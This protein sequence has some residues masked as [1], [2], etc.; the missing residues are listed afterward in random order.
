[1]LKHKYIKVKS[2]ISGLLWGA[3]PVLAILLSSCFTGIEG[4]KKITLSRQDRKQTA[5]TAE[6]LYLSDVAPSSSLEWESGK[7]FFVADSRA[8]VLIDAVEVASPGR[9]GL[10]RGDILRYV[11]SRE[12]RMPDGSTRTVI[13]FS[14]GAGEEFRYVAADSATGAGAEG[15]MSDAIP[16]LIDPVM[17]KAVGDRLRGTD[18]WTRS[19]LWLDDSDNR[20]SGLKYD[21][22]RVTDVAPG[23]MV[24]PVRVT[25]EDYSGNRGSYL[26]NYGNTGIDS[27]GFS[28]LFS[29]TD[30][31]AS[32]P[33]ISDEVWNLICREKVRAGMTKE[34]CRLAKGNPSDVHT[35]HD[36]S[37]SML[38]WIYPDA[39]TL[40]FEDDLLVRVKSYAE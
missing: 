39:T 19:T 40:Y 35:G 22:V 32:Y 31:R 21:R 8:S 6:E 18:L 25:F 5:P 24:F 10:E 30:P 38:L 34:E 7:A 23:S 26:M 9:E 12:M 11:E 37:K 4:T 3:M 20:Q 14:R 29:L 2:R 1:M 28:N 15:V 33:G 27:R 17:V 13:V 16:G 36:Y